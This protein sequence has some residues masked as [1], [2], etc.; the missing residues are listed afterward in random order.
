MKSTIIYYLTTMSKCIDLVG[1]RYGK[2]TV[3]ERK[4]STEGKCKHALWLCHCDCG[5][6]TITTTGRL[7]SG[8][9]QSCGCLIKEKA[10]RKITDLTGQKIG[11]LT[12]I[13]RDC[14]KTKYVM[15]ICKCDCGNI[16]SCR[17]SNLINKKSTSC[18]CKR[19]ETLSNN[20][21]IKHG[22]AR[23]K[24]HPLYKVFSSMY[25]RCYV[26]KHDSYIHYGARG[27]TI[28]PEWLNDR[29]SFIKWAEEHGYQ[30][31]LQIDRIDN[32]GNY[33]PSNCRFITC[34]ENCRNRRNNI[35]ITIN[36]ERKT[37][38]E[39]CEILNLNYTHIRYIKYYY[40]IERCR[41]EIKKEYDRFMEIRE[42]KQKE[43]RL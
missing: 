5:N 12:V 42:L 39:W 2:L 15:W 8:I 40:G 31:G 9:T 43:D 20:P 3:I 26:K 32:N 36:G 14:R 30:K 11:R 10:K 37:I 13:E 28:A 34:K 24:L 21:T 6:D 41:D 4:G 7:N 1:K 35:F 18:G 25:N 29:A 23:G 38:K 19:I 17:S 33:E 27:I 16:I 22:Y